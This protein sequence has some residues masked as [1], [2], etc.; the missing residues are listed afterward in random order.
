[1]RGVKV[2]VSGPI[3]LGG[4]LHS[5]QVAENIDRIN[6]QAAAL[7]AQGYEVLNPALLQREGGEWVDYMEE[8]IA[9]LAQA[10]LIFLVDGWERSTGCRIEAAIA[11]H[12]RIGE[13][14]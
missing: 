1:M 6:R 13:L 9:M 8:S 5:D 14:S 7:A 12:F 11:R 2:Y 3:S 10:D 4:T